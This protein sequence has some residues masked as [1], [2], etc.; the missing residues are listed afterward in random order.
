MLAIA[1]V[2]WYRWKDNRFRLSLVPYG[3]LTAVFISK[4]AGLLIEFDDLRAVGDDILLLPPIL[5]M[6]VIAG[7]A[8]YST[9]KVRERRGT[10]RI[11]S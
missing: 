3:L 9:R 7:Y 10:E 6:M 8:L 5:V 2:I 11:P 1:S 4:I